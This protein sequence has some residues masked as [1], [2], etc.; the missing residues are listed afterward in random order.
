MTI[1]MGWCIIQCETYEGRKDYMKKG[2]KEGRKEGLYEGMKDYMKEG[3]YE[4]RKEGRKEG[5]G[6]KYYM[7]E[8]GKEGTCAS[9]AL[10]RSHGK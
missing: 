3:L 9:L 5:N 10:I 2:R 8:E 7:K 4:G 6:R 1:G